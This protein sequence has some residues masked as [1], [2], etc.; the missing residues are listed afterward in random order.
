MTWEKPSQRSEPP[1]ATGMTVR[2]I[3]FQELHCHLAGST[4]LF[5][6]EWEA[7]ECYISEPL[8]M[9]L[10]R[11]LSSPIGVGFFFVKKKD[12][13]LRPCI[14]Y[15]ALNEITTCNKYLLPLLDAAS[16]STHLH[17]AGSPRNAYHLVHFRQ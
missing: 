14:D 16:Q 13:S 11:P 6:L 1:T 3:C 10:K 4:N 15:Q 12:G 5:W 17:Q 9:G 2:S 7:M 8:S